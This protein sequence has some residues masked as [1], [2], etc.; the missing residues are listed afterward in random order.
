MNAY[1][2]TEKDHLKMMLGLTEKVLG[3]EG[4]ETSPH[5]ST[6]KRVDM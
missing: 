5:K 2:Q 6:F 1:T 3:R 4:T